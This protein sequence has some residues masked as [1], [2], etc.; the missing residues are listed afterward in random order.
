MYIIHIHSSQRRTG[1]ATCAPYYVTQVAPTI[2]HEQRLPLSWMGPPRS[3]RRRSSSDTHSLSLTKY[4]NTNGYIK[5]DV[6]LWEKCAR[7]Q[8]Q[9]FCGRTMG[10]LRCLVPPINMSPFLIFFLLFCT[11]IVRTLKIDHARAFVAFV[12]GWRVHARIRSHSFLPRRRRRFK[13]WLFGSLSRAKFYE[14]LIN[15]ARIMKLLSC[16]IVGLQWF[17]MKKR[18]TSMHLA[19]NLS[20]IN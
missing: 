1:W 16:L 20:H 2:T 10:L 11:L 18:W 8:Q 6:T 19:L 17:L 5:S 12:P 7:A 9:V 14:V 4:K 15:F 3:R 13:K